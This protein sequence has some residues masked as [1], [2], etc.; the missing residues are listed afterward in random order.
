MNV[1]CAWCGDIL[2]FDIDDMSGNLS[3]GICL[4]CVMKECSEAG[5]DPNLYLTRFMVQKQPKKVI[6]HT[7]K[8]LEDSNKHK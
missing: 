4:M 8:L 5:I 6:K 2:I 1:K 3:H 7:D